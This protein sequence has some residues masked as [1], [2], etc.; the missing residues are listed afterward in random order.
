MRKESEESGVR[1]FSD[2]SL[3]M[4]MAMPSSQLL[5]SETKTTTSTASTG[6]PPP[7]RRSNL[8]GNDRLTGWSGWASPFFTAINLLPRRFSCWT[9]KPWA[10]ANQ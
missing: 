6:H 5:Q 2:G 4:S 8:G 10:W 9:Q 3:A 7:Y 1:S